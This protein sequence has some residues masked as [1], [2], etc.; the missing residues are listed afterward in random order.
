[1][2]TLIQLNKNIFCNF[3]ILLLSILILTLLNYLFFVN[4]THLD[5]YIGLILGV[6][7]VSFYLAYLNK[8][9]QNYYIILLVLLVY[10]LLYY[11]PF[12]NYYYGFNYRWSYSS[13]EELYIPINLALQSHFVLIVGYIY[14][15]IGL[16]K[17]PLLLR[18]LNF[19]FNIF[20]YNIKILTYI[21]IFI[22]CIFILSTYGKDTISGYGWMLYI[23]VF[24]G[25][26]LPYANF[27]LSKWVVVISV[28]I[29]LSLALFKSNADGAAIGSVIW[30]FMMLYIYKN[31]YKKYSYAVFGICFVLIIF[32]LISK[33]H[34]N[35]E[36]LDTFV[37]GLIDA[38]V[39]N[40][41]RL[42]QIHLVYDVFTLDYLE[43]SYHKFF[44]D[45]FT[46]LPNFFIGFNLDYAPEATKVI[47]N[48][49]DMWGSIGGSGVS[50][51]FADMNLLGIYVYFI[52][53]GYIAAMFEKI[54]L[55]N[56]KN[57]VLYMFG[58]LFIQ[59][60][61]SEGLRVS[62]IY[63]LLFPLFVLGRINIRGLLLKRN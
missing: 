14:S 27:I 4:S 13:I 11:I 54:E 7:L 29:M 49:Q 21:Y 39:I 35:L 52:F 19:N 20:S 37:A 16:N 15:T 5:V 23:I 41:G 62:D 28:I 32:T 12:L 30:F 26:F 55:N 46:F 44:T 45:F 60:S 9:F 43:H 2:S 42:E 57:L 3:T 24:L 59:H 40:V 58:F 38:L 53:Y 48:K 10:I 50:H 56:R 31:K 36:N 34:V 63:F 6:F 8:N 61:I 1:M 33:S 22:W 51:A 47:Y 25:T 18:N 17:F